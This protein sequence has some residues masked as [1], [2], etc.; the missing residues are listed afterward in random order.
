MRRAAP[1]AEA[2][3]RPA[4]RPHAAVASAAGCRAMTATLTQGPVP[5]PSAPPRP[6]RRSCG[7]FWVRAGLCDWPTDGD[8]SLLPPPG[9]VQ[10]HDEPVSSQASRR[11]H[12]LTPELW[13]LEHSRSTS[14]PGRSEV[15]RFPYLYST[16]RCDL[17]AAS[18]RPP[19][20]AP[21]WQV[22]LPPPARPPHY[23]KDDCWCGERRL[24]PGHVPRD[25][26]R[27]NRF[28]VGVFTLIREVGRGEITA[29]QGQK[30][31]PGEPAA[32]EPTRR[33]RVPNK[34]VGF[35]SLPPGSPE[36]PATPG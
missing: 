17:E 31:G 16:L 26:I 14:D 21:R 9:K 29:T 10:R 23:P 15:G 1:R 11:P 22:A 25:R 13:R 35:R 7:A 20:T 27:V 33:D 8:G 32:G 34:R 3:A 19:T 5:G 12:H 6:C 4:G 30:P 28:H 18:S 36:E 24:V 2:G